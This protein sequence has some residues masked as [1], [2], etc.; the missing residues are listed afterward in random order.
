M[1]WGSDKKQVNNNLFVCFSRYYRFG[2]FYGAVFMFS[3]SPVTV[4][5]IMLS[6]I[7][8]ISKYY[9]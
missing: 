9:V 5:F 7:I 4:I 3:L 6:G 2:H 1:V 8:S